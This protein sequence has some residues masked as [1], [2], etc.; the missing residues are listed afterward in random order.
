MATT[1]RFVIEDDVVRQERIEV[2][3]TLPL[4]AVANRLVVKAPATFPLLPASAPTRFLAYDENTGLGYIILEKQPRKHTIQVRHY[5]G[6]YPDDEERADENGIARFDVLLPYHYFGFAFR[7][8]A[9]QTAFTVYD[10][11][12]FFRKTP[13]TE[14][15]TLLW[16]AAT[17]NVDDAGGI[18]WGATVHPHPTMAEH[19]DAMV[20]EFF[21]SVFNEDLGHFTPFGHSLTE[22]EENSE[23][24]GAWMDWPYWDNVAPRTLDQVIADF[25]DGL[26]RER[27]MYTLNPAFVELPEMPENFSVARAVEWLNGLRP[28]QRHRIVLAASRTAEA[29]T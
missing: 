3:R 5:S 15:D 29:T 26:P 11:Q 20:N 2:I 23:P 1:E 16:P 28:E 8:R 12:L 27:D 7:K 22:W 10:G 9:N 18:C 19:I 13:Y 25:G 4:E 24:F 6:N 14:T 17:P 21:V